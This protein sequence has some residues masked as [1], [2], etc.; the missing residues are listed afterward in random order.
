MDAYT[1]IIFVTLLRKEKLRHFKEGDPL[2]L[3]SF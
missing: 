1:V 3:A 2:F